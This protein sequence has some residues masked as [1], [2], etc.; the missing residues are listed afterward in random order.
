MP[1]NTIYIGRPSKFGN[2]NSVCGK[3]RQDY[4]MAVA[5]Y[6]AELRAVNRIEESKKYIEMIKKELKGKDVCCW[7]PLE[8][9]CHGDAVLQ[10][11][12]E[13]SGPFRHLDFKSIPLGSIDY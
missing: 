5:L 9:P 11:A 1:P 8:M 12:N 13:W 2:Q 10:I 6:I 4:A 3:E 7:C